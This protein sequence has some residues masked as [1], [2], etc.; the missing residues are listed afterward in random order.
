MPPITKTTDPGPAEERPGQ[1]ASPDSD[2]AETGSRAPLYGAGDRAATAHGD[3]PA[4]ASTETMTT[5]GRTPPASEP[6]PAPVGLVAAGDRCA[7]CA[8]PL[9]ADQRYCLNC[10]ERRG[11]ARFT[12]TPANTGSTGAARPDPPPRGSRFS[13]GTTL[14]AGVATL[15]LALGI[16]VVIGNQ[17]ASSPAP[18]NSKAQVVY[19]NGAGAGAASTGAA[20]T[21]VPASSGGSSGSANKSSGKSNNKS[22]AKA[23]TSASSSTAAAA[24][25]AT[26]AQQLPPAT[27][28]VGAKGHGAGYQHGKFTGNFFGP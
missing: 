3:D 8:A 12:A 9:A 19:L 26:T 10:G 13:A 25:S 17:S 21:T 27:V 24:S 2:L 4:S 11:A 16:G 6:A 22:A 28:T 14:I 23:S 15:L 1:Y 18:T 7:N 20:P 5:T